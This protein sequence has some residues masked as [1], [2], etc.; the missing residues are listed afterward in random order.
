MINLFLPFFLIILQGLFT[1][2]ETGV[3]SIERARLG[4]LR[5]ERRLWAIR[6]AHFISSPGRFFST[7][8]ICEDLLLVIAS[9]LYAQFFITH[10]G[11]NSIIFSTIILSLFSLIIGQYIPKSIALSNPELALSLLAAPIYYIELVTLPISYIFSEISRS[12]AK[13]FK[14]QA[15][16]DLIRHLDIIFAMGEY[17]KEAS[18]LASRLFN[19]SKRT[20]A[21]VMIPL[22]AV[23]L[24][25]KDVALQNLCQEIGRL[26]TRIPVYENNQDN[27]IGIL[28]IKDYFY[29]DRLVLR[30]PFFINTNERCMTIFLVM[31]EK[32]EHMAIVRDNNCKVLGIVTLEDLFEELVG[33]IR[34]ER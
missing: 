5:R 6:T 18:K 14:G 15:K 26:Y 23:F 9:T 31:K 28:N 11:N 32:G 10:F 1:A 13:L 8:L 30:P 24:C 2:T 17:E 21:E 20:V 4:R 22:P 25:K 27:I 7:I 29:N 12:I 33:E 3:L 19:F 34:E 16:A